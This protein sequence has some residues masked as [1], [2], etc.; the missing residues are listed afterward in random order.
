M[1]PLTCR[2]L[3]TVFA[4]AAVFS[5]IERASAQAPVPPASGE[6]A[7]LLSELAREVRELRIEVAVLRLSWR[8][9]RLRV[10]EEQI[11]AAERDGRMADYE[12]GS[13]REDILAAETLLAGSD[14]DPDERAEVTGL[15]D[16][17]VNEGQQQLHLRRSEAAGRESALRGEWE[18]E[19]AAAD[20]CRHD[21]ATLQSDAG[22]LSGVNPA[23]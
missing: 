2:T 15:K 11:R 10:L 6:P 9:Q 1:K 4:L 22:V 16:Q 3:R 13:G 7:K 14:L 23:R 20:K 8:E 17:L 18:R 19:R 5:S 12:E 21:L